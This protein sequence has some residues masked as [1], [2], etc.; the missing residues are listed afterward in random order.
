MPDREHV[1]PQKG[2]C[3]SDSFPV[4]R[5]LEGYVLHLLL[6]LERSL[7]LWCIIGNRCSLSSFATPLAAATA[8]CHFS[9]ETS[10]AKS[11]AHVCPSHRLSIRHYIN[12]NPSPQ[13]QTLRVLSR[14]TS[15]NVQQTPILQNGAMLTRYAVRKQRRPPN[16]CNAMALRWAEN[17]HSFAVQSTVCLRYR[18]TVS[19]SAVVI[20]KDPHT[21]LPSPLAA[22]H[23]RD[24]K[25][26]PAGRVKARP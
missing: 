11:G 16:A 7:L 5:V 10:R 14:H 25:C 22:K 24:G 23:V 17:V 13:A 9:V 6:V 15:G 3:C 20:A 19:S 8:C 26:S 12:S 2:C 21:M 4:I 18:L 1:D